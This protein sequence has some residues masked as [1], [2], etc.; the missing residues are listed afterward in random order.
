MQLKITKV[1]VGAIFAV[2]VACSPIVQEARKAEREERI[3]SNE[4]MLKTYPKSF[5]PGSPKY[6]ERDF[7]AG[8]DFI[9]DEFEN[10]YKKDFCAE[11]D[12]NWRR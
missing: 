7:E 3:I 4:M 10:K 5:R 6:L 8:A 2:L 11:P 1:G 9:C 12:I